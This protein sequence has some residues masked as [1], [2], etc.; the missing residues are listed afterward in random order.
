MKVYK[1][2]RKEMCEL[3]DKL[4]QQ[5]NSHRESSSFVEGRTEAYALV[6]QWLEEK[7]DVGQH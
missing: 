1:W 4:V 2:T 5:G 7:K 3:L 6:K